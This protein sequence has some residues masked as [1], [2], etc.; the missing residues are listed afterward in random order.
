MNR[1]RRGRCQVPAWLIKFSSPLVLFVAPFLW[2]Y[3]HIPA[4]VIF[5]AIL[6][7]L[8]YYLFAAPAICGAVKS[9]SKGTCDKNVYGVLRACELEAHKRKKRQHLLR[10]L[11]HP[12]TR[13]PPETRAAA[14]RSTVGPTPVYSYTPPAQPSPIKLET[15]VSVAGVAISALSLILSFIVWQFPVK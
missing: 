7:S 6:T 8:L 5:W 13:P 9:D 2:L 14:P 11:R 3:Y 1:G 10:Q 12:L 15:V 4:V